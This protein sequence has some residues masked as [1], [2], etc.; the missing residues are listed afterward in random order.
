MAIRVVATVPGQYNQVLRLVGEVFELLCYADGTYPVALRYTP[1]LDAAGKP[2][3]DEWDEHQ[4]IGKDKKPV[5]RDFAEDQGEKLIKKGPVRGDV[6]RFGWMKRVPDRIPVGLYP[7]G[8]DFWS[9]SIPQPI[10]NQ[11]TGLPYQPVP[12]ANERGPEDRR[13]NHAPI[14][15]VLPKEE[16]EAAA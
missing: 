3:P 2:I 15:T 6:I 8:A 11:L 5:H 16:V 9:G 1:K 7:E 12:P 14:L 13:R 4:V 10:M